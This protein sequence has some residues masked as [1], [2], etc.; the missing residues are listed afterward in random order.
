VRTP[1]VTRENN[2][3]RVN[4]KFMKRSILILFI[5]TCLTSCNGQEKN[6]LSRYDPAAVQ[7]NNL[8]MD[9]YNLNSQ[10]TDSIS[11]SVYLLT[12]AI[13][14]D[15]TYYLAYGNKA[16]LLC[17]IGK[18]D[19]AIAV[20]DK[21]L[22]QKKDIVELLTFKGFLFEKTGNV[23]KAMEIYNSALSLYNQKLKTDSSNISLML[24]RAF[25]YFFVEGN[26]R[27]IKEFLIISDTYP[28]NDQV[29]IM[30]DNFL[31]FD[32]KVYIDSIC[33]GQ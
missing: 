5:V 22:T 29:T 9:I 24:N 13:Q 27:A 16:S 25:I 19:E 33:N 3:C 15:S 10:N 12:L 23:S 32:R 31:L 2:N 11:K 17:Q 8:A 7:L 21:I 28:N 26:D 6:S 30:K 18:S 4:I 20:L 1:H 14:K